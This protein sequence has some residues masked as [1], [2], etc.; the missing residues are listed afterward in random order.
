MNRNMY[1]NESEAETIAERFS[2]QMFYL[3]PA[4]HKQTMQQLAS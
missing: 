1:I 3:M 2:G 4:H